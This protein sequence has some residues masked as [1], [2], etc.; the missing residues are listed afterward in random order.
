MATGITGIEQLDQLIET[1]RGAGAGPEYAQAAARS[2]ETWL[3][4]NLAAGV[5]PN[6]TA[7][8]EPTKEGKRPLKSAASRPTVTL[9]GSNVV[10]TLSG[11]YVFQHFPTRGR[12]ARRV[13]PQGRMPPELGNAIRAG[14]VEP[15]EAK[16][17]AGKRGYAAT[18]ARA[19]NGGAT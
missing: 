6:T 17:K 10:I 3:R 16:T 11:Y 1:I 7:V 2:V 15:F 5:D 18:K 12:V 19:G 4:S 8:W 9:A 14:M 13:I